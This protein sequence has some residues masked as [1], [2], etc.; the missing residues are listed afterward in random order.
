MNDIAPK[1]ETHPQ[2][3]WQSR[4]SELADHAIHNLSNRDDA[5]GAYGSSGAYCHKITD[6]IPEARENEILRR[7]KS[8]FN[9]R[10]IG[11]LYPQSKPDESGQWVARF[12]CIDLDLKQDHP[13]KE[14]RRLRNIDYALHI[15]RKLESA[16][17][18]CVIEDSNGRGALHV[19]FWLNE[20]IPVVRLYGFLTWLVSDAEHH[21]FE[22]SFQRVDENEQPRFL[23]DGNPDMGDDRPETFPKQSLPTGKGLG[24]FIRLPGRH[25]T[26]DHYSRCWGDGDW[27]S[28]DDSVDAWLSLPASDVSLI[29]E[30][31]AD[32]NE[33]PKP[34]RTTKEVT[35]NAKEKL[36]TLAERT[37]DTERWCDLLEG[38]GWN[39]IGD[40]GGAES[41][42]TRPGKKGGVSATLNFKGNNLLHVFSSAV[43]GLDADQNY[44]KWR[45]YL[46]TNGF[47]NRQVEAAK[48]YLP[49]DVVAEHD[50]KSLEDWKEKQKLD[51]NGKPDSQS[52]PSRTFAGKSAAELW[53]LADQPVEWLVEG[54]FSCDQ[55]T[56]FGAKQ[57]SLK[58]TLLTDLAVALASG[59][60][61][62]GKFKIPKKRRVLFVTGEASEAAAIRKVR[63][64]AESRNLRRQDFTDSLRIEAIAFPT[65]PSKSDCEAVGEAVKEH[66]IEVVL[67]D[68]LYM[69]LQGVNTANLTEVGPALRMFMQYCRPA[70]VMIAH[71]VKKTASFDDAPN[72]EDLSQAGIAEF[73]GNYW[74]MGRMSEYTGDGMHT[75]AI[76]AGGRD[77]QFHLLKLEFDE[78]A[79][80]SEFSSLQG[81]RD[82]QQNRKET[83]RINALTAKILTELGRYPSGISES[84]LAGAV[85]TRAERGAFQTALG[86]LE[87]RGVIICLREFKPD[88]SKVTKGWMLAQ[89]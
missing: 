22:Q 11:G 23:P 74:L 16:Q 4:A 81:H 14:F 89:K 55:P 60:P 61:W 36:G 56:I 3:Q 63:R 51:E 20:S 87:G 12:G 71:H 13:R 54:V 46:G 31:T 77:E 28:E 52:N 69:G 10:T 84:K 88:R 85:G 62:L 49:V 26:H 5:M 6:D 43:S 58:T 68:P 35:I 34:A 78:R 44:G 9:G 53:D 79:W 21:G 41:T 73:A 32:E 30:V 45:F 19:W 48:A 57:K 50:R 75:L 7:L 72:L 42:W 66:G 70:N 17:L 2:N 80:T 76:R 59:M 65:L 67:L 39:K 18:R 47:E 25:H 40:N 86:E 38:S 24:N 29:P 33:H 83:V 64:A 37:I 15:M 27:L 1:P 8:H 82:D